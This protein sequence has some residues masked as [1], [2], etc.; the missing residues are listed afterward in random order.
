MSCKD[1]GLIHSIDPC[2][3]RNHCHGGEFGKRLDPVKDA[4]SAHEGGAANSAL[5]FQDM[6]GMKWSLVT[7][8]ETA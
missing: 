1:P 5:C 8:D 2:Q 7:V 6:L 3:V 4:S